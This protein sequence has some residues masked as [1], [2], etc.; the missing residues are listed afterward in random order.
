MAAAMRLQRPPRVPVMCQLSLGHYFLNTDIP[1]EDI[2]FDAEGFSA[3]LVALARRYRFDG[4]LVNLWSQSSEWRSWIERIDEEPDGARTLRWKRGGFCRIPPDDNLHH[5]PP[6]VPPALED[7]DPADIYYDDPHGPGGLKHPFYFGLDPAARSASDYFPDYLF[8]TIDLLR[9]G[10]GADL[11]IHGEVFSP[12]TQ[13][14]ELF[15][16]QNAMM[17]LMTDA[18][19]CCDILARYAEGAA[20]L[21]VRLA[22]RGVDAVLISS[23]FAGAGFISREFYRRFVQPYERRVVAAVKTARPDLPVYVHTCGSIGDR[24]EMMLESGMNGIDTLDPP[25]LGNVD[26][27]DAVCRLRGRA[28]IKGNMDPVNTL[29]RGDAETVREDAKRRVLTAGPAGGYILS[30]ACSVA[31]RVKPEN[32]MVLAEVADE[33]GRFG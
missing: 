16:Y 10:E 22:R 8:R 29:L 25:P 27:A 24:L 4:V 2:W 3:A 12:F 11:S 17:H 31:P 20:D 15:G 9:A 33:H 21:A 1:N 7:V 26:L 18:G 30:S 28:F 14:M 19:K 5:F 23:A 32:L 6:Y 13:L